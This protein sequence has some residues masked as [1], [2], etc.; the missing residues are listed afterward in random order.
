MARRAFL[1]WGKVIFTRIL[2]NR[3]F[4][5]N[6]V[7]QNVKRRCFETPA[8]MA[9]RPWWG[10]RIRFGR[11]L[12]RRVKRAFENNSLIKNTKSFWVLLFLKGGVFRSFLEKASPKTFMIS[13]CY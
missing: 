5:G 12:Q 11:G 4:S 2:R 10:R 1:R 13:G 8:M 7:L 9:A 3:Y 6:P